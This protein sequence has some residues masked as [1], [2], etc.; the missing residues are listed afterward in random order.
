MPQGPADNLVNTLK[1]TFVRPVQGVLS[2]VDKYIPDSITGK[3]QPPDTSYHDDMVNK[4]TQ[5]FGAKPGPQPAKPKAPVVPK[6]HKGTDYVPK[7]GPAILQKGEAVLNKGDADK[8]REGKMKNKTYDVSDELAGKKEDKPKKEIKH[9]ITRKDH[10]GKGHIH[11][12]VHTNPAAHPDEEH[13]T[14]G[15]DEM[16]EHMMQNMGTPNPGE[17][18][19]DA[20]QSGVPAG[21]SLMPG[22]AAGAPAPAAGPTGGM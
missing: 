17:A 22:A 13:V 2:T 10:G 5:S 19:A 3:K 14:N 8:M 4:A 7:T 1:N 11:T 20:G 21:A 16:A 12:H 9:I 15:D 6:F 18:E